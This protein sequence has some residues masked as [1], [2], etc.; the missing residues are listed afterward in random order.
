M[1]VL[2]QR[3]YKWIHL[4]LNGEEAQ[5]VKNWNNEH[6]VFHN[7]MKNTH[8]KVKIHVKYKYACKKNFMINV[9]LQLQLV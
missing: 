9:K 7:N 5:T 1:I 6:I 4:N 8:N 3:L 2:F